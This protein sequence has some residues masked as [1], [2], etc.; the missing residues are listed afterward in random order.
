MPRI[1]KVNRNALLSRLRSGHD[2]E[3]AAIAAGL[4]EKQIDIAKDDF[5]T[6]ITNAFKTGTG[7]LRSRIMES[8]LSSD[9][10]AILMK[11]L[12]QRETAQAVADSS[13][14][15]IEWE[16]VSAICANCG[17]KYMKDENVNDIYH[18]RK[19]N[20]DGVYPIENNGD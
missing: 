13:I 6:E 7:K 9:N 3:S 4:S 2:L 5:G 14:K 12:E 8:A 20:S 16:I 1:S 17:H 19:R 18:A 15:K 10:S 11:I